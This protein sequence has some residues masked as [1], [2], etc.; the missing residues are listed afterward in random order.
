[1]V[2]LM[3]FQY[4]AS[5]K[6][7]FVLCNGKFG[8]TQLP[9]LVIDLRSVKKLEIHQKLHDTTKIHALFLTVY[10]PLILIARLIFSVDSWTLVDHMPLL[11]HAIHSENAC[12]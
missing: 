10:Y 5:D 4:G 3:L 11:R 9:G 12:C 8:F 1:M 7:T 2:V 6:V